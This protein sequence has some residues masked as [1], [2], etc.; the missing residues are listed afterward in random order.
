VRA[1]DAD[2]DGMMVGEGL[3]M[4]V[5]KRLADAERDGDRIY[6]VI[7]GVGSSSDGRFKSIYAPRSSGQ[8]QALRRAYAE[9]GYSP[10][11]VGLIEAHGTGTMAGDPA[12]FQGLMEVFGEDNPHRQYIALGSIKSQ[13]AHTKATAGTASLIK[14]TLALYHKV[15]PAT[16]NVKKPNPK[17]DVENSPFYINTETRPWIQT[18]ANIPRRAGISSF[19]FGG[20]NFHVALEEYR[21][22]HEGAYRLQPVAQLILLSAATPQELLT[23][24]KNT[25]AGLQKDGKQAF[26]NLTDLS[27]Q[28]HPAQKDARIGFL[29]ASLA[30]AL[31]MLQLAV[32]TLSERIADE[33]W[34]HPKGVYYRKNGMHTDGSI[35]ALFS[36]QGSQYVDM[37]RELTINF[38]PM[39]KVFSAIDNL[40]LQD[41]L[42]PLSRKVFPIPVF[43][44][45]H[46][47]QQSKELT[48]TRHAQPAI[49]ALGAGMFKILQAAGFQPDFTAGHSFGEWTALWAAGVLDDENYY[50]LAKA[51]GKAMA[52]PDD[53]GFDAGTMVAVKGDI[54][55][56]RAE[57]QNMPEITL[58]NIN[59][60]EQ[61]VLA[62]ARAAIAKASQALSERG[63][64]VTPLPVSA[65]FHTSLVGHAQKPFAR[66]IRSAKFNAPAVRV[67]SNSTGKQHSTDAAEIK[68]VMEG[69]IL[70]PVLWKDEIDEIYTA[71]GRIFIE[72]GPKNVL[73]NLVK[74]ILEGKPHLAIALNASAKK[75]SDRQFR[76]AVMQLR[77]AGLR[78][79]DFDPYQAKITRPEKKK[80]PLTI[81]LHGGYY[82]SEKTKAAFENA[83]KDGFKVK[84]A[85]A[86]PVPA[87]IAPAPTA[88]A[89]AP[90]PASNPA[91]TPVVSAQPVQQASL[92]HLAQ[93]QSHQSET[94]R[95][96]AQYLQNEEEYARTY[97]Q[98]TQSGLKLLENSSSLTPGALEQLVSVLQGLQQSL[99]KF[100]EHQAETLR[101]HEQYLKHQ[102]T[103]SQD[104]LKLLQSNPALP[105]N[106]SALHVAAGSEP[107]SPVHLEIA[108]AP[109]QFTP[110]TDGNQHGN[111]SAKTA[112]PGALQPSVHS[113]QSSPEPLPA[114]VIASPPVAAPVQVD[115][116]ARLLEVISEKTG[117]PGEMLE[118]EMDMEADLGIDSIKRVEILGAMRAHF[119]DLPKVDPEAFAEMRT[120]TQVIDHIHKTLPTPGSAVA[121]APPV[122]VVSPAPPAMPSAATLDV[123]DPS[124][125]EVGAALL[126]IVSEKTGYPSEMLELGMDMEAD[127]GID[128]IK[129]VEILGAMRNVYPDL[130]KV[131]PEV[132]AEMRTLAQ[133]IEHIQKT[134]P[135]N[136]AATPAAVITEAVSQSQPVAVII[137]TTSRPDHSNLVAALLEVVSEKTGYPSEM[138]ELEMDMEADLGIDSI[139]R[140]EILGAMRNVYPDLPKVAPEAFA[141]LRTLGQVTE[142]IRTHLLDA[143]D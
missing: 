97:A 126:A 115:V 102:H 40:F 65:A 35:V 54:E 93:F 116:A 129:R 55:K 77:V 36:G 108:H 95:I 134:L 56:V 127:L 48:Q 101:V 11:T 128:S 53:P 47:E 109:V 4:V 1:F 113:V 58:A 139:K 34:E 114:V 86:A 125:D 66:A 62:G 120:L 16:L 7:R 90:Q 121:A 91:A 135:G 8:A 59:S 98:L 122:A 138:L 71:G 82:V 64:A 41:G 31:Q 60:R 124:A 52:P 103:F 46:L 17:L 74:N 123:R 15:L 136:G 5:L 42:E 19:G 2:S 45:A 117:Y 23:Q 107:P 39:R 96:H 49:G 28:S 73:T 94:A 20:T 78:L 118:L 133:V 143:H 81:K 37:G 18:D 30:E 105:T 63:Y 61:V 99:S 142:H 27:R 51:R 12:E 76:E 104:F 6:A 89:E 130:P 111:G 50:A 75:D 21:G 110:K 132:F 32:D 38:P 140:V 83:L 92:P 29:A 88:V 25:L 72:F 137:P 68:K 106:G 3:G 22:E 10:Q 79:G 70:N 67:Y 80:S 24:C 87:V 85:M 14:A 112:N 119:P 84:Q 131:E 13:I 57:I 26:L 69:H 43:D 44:D 141:E 100:H 9:A 33:S